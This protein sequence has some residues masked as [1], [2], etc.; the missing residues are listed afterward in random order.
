MKISAGVRIDRR[1]AL[2]LELLAKGAN[3]TPPLSGDNVW[4]AMAIW[5]PQ[6]AFR[7]IHCAEALTKL[8]STNS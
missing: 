6:L 7:P 8:E 1:E 4:L 5:N 2:V 3:A